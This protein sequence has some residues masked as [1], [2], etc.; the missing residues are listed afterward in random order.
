MERVW[1]VADMTQARTAGLAGRTDLGLPAEEWGEVVRRRHK[2]EAVVARLRDKRCV[3][4]RMLE[5][6]LKPE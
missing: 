3:Q 4:V 5:F 1:A 6:A 2:V